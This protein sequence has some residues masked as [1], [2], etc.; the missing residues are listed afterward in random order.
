[1][2]PPLSFLV[3]L[4]LSIGA[5]VLLGVGI[6]MA[7]HWPIL[8]RRTRQPLPQ[9]V[10]MALGQFLFWIG[11]PLSII[12][13]IYRA[14][15]SGNLI[16][17][18]TVAWVAMLLGLGCSQVW[19]GPRRA[20][21]SRPSQGSFSLASML[22]NTGYI[23]YPV[24]LLLPQLG[25]AYF[26]WALFYDT[27]GTLLGSYGLG[28][29]LASQYGDRPLRSFGSCPYWLLHLKEVLLNP[30]ILA[31]LAG[32]M[33]RSVEFPAILDAGL[34]RFAWLMV[35]L[36]LVLM[37]IRL[38]QISSWQHLQSAAI[39]V[40]IKMG[41]LPVVIGLG[42]T[43]LGMDGPARLVLVLQAGMPCAFANLVLAEAYQLDRELTVTCVGLSSAML[44][45]TLPLWLW[46]FS[47]NP[48]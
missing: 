36:S 2:F 38:Q 3:Q 16:L 47:V 19:L 44:M 34:Y 13:F 7:L 42:L 28:V 10:P 41:I 39:V 24:V 9:W 14:D 43:L 6:G 27:L 15:L 30:T 35:M 37:G 5:A 23:G 11:V 31:F 25:P 32:L 18:P 48:I 33:L 26:G 40:A 21:W 12:S 4:Y 29:F 22:G 17:A 45:L 8:Q 1:M 20:T 46:G